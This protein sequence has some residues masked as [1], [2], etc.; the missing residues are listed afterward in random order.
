[1][2]SYGCTPSASIELFE[3]LE[4]VLFVLEIC[5]KLCWDLVFSNAIWQTVSSDTMCF[6]IMELI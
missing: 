3:C 5:G 4:A 1:M 6:E 2:T